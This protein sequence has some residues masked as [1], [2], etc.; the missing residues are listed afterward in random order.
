MNKQIIF[1]SYKLQRNLPENYKEQDF[2]HF[3]GD[4]HN[5]IREMHVLELKNTTVLHNL[6]FHNMQ[7]LEQYCATRPIEWKRRIKAYVKRII[8]KSIKI[9]EATW[10][11]DNWS[12][13]YF[14]WITDV[15]PRIHVAK[16]FLPSRPI[17]LPL[18]FKNLAFVQESIKLLDVSVIYF[19][20]YIKYKIK[21]IG[22]TSH[23]S[24]CSFDKELI[25]QVRIDFT[26]D[27]DTFKIN[28]YKRI[29]I[30]RSK[31]KRRR[32]SNE[33]S[34]LTVLSK[35]NIDCHHMEDLSFEEQRKLM[36]ETK[37]LISNHGAGL[38]NMTF[39]QEGATIFEL[40]SD[41]KNINNCFFNLARSLDHNYY[42]T[43]NQGK[44][45]NLQYT[46]IDVDLDILEI[47]LTRIFSKIY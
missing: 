18:K 10:L 11:I 5:T 31:A 40:K 36:A 26:K 25:R 6:I 27:I 43:I 44:E 39:M 37:F 9:D 38:T 45:D 15:L 28:P 24:S 22:L 4:I 35:F 29:Y 32:I 16:K 3:D 7:I 47:E 1:K 46:D 33:K 13:G 14:H 17:L 23:L 12:G 21:N 8:Y 2:R 19:Q 30:S 20:P 41:S 42:Y 34:L